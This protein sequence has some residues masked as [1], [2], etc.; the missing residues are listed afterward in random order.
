MAQAT[1]AAGGLQVF[2]DHALVLT[3]LQELRREVNKMPNSQEGL[4]PNPT[5]N[6]GGL[7]SLEAACRP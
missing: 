3:H 2:Q 7:D 4:V 5:R 1:S 6:G